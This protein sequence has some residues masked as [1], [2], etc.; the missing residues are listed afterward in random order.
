LAYRINADEDFKY[1]TEY[2]FKCNTGQA[3]K[4]IRRPVLLLFSIIPISNAGKSKNHFCCTGK[5]FEATQRDSCDMKG[6]GLK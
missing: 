5:E 1:I 2:H 4:K 6:T 3:I